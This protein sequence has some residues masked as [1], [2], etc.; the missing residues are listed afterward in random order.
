MSLEKKFWTLKSEKENQ[1]TLLTDNIRSIQNEV[2]TKKREMD[3]LKLNMAND[4]ELEIRNLKFKNELEIK[5]AQQMEAKDA[6]LEE[7]NNHIN[8]LEK[9]LHL[10][11]YAL[12]A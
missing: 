10:G 6:H 5:F 9:Q 8:G 1:Q 3:H 12:E 2:L 4:Q 11:K 7:L